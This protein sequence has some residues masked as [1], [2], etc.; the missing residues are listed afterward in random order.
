MLPRHMVLGEGVVGGLDQ[1]DQVAFPEE[2]K[3]EM[4]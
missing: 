3:I 2:V 1:L 4:M